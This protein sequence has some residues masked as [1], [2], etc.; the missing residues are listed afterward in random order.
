VHLS[1]KSPAQGSVV[2]ELERCGTARGRLVNRAGLPVAEYRGSGPLAMAVTP[3]SY[4]IYRCPDDSRIAAN[5]STLTGIDPIH[6]ADGPMSD[7]LGRITFPALI[8]G[9]TY[10]RTPRN[11]QEASDNTEFIVRPGETL[12]LGDLVI[13]ERRRQ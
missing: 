3:G 6:Y 13:E 8:P 4:P 1:G 2:V 7:S 10:R 11:T 9:A 12:S 5:V